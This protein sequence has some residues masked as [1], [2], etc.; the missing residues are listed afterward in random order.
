MQRRTVRAHTWMVPTKFKKAP[1][2]GLEFQGWLI[3]LYFL[4][5]RNTTSTSARASIGFTQCGLEFKGWL[6]R[7]YFLRPRKTS[8]LSAH[9]FICRTVRVGVLTTANQLVLLLPAGS[10]HCLLAPAW[11]RAH[12][13]Y[14]RLDGC[15]GAGSA[16]VL[17]ARHPPHHSLPYARF[18]LSARSFD[19]RALASLLSSGDGGTGTSSSAQDKELNRARCRLGSRQLP[20]NAGGAQD[21]DFSVQRPQLLHNSV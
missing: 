10:P 17:T 3:S 21:K 7:S 8:S 2:N 19:M 9:D 6:I 11:L 18:L 1:A 20:R 4:R 14:G 5:Q 15:K 12:S 16:R 13:T